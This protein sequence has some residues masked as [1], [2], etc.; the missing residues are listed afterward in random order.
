MIPIMRSCNDA[1]A[2]DGIW[3]KFIPKDTIY[4]KSPLVK[5]LVWYRFGDGQYLM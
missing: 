3:Q 4:I 5:I 2:V 1:V